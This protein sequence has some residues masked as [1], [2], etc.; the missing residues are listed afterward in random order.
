MKSIVSTTLASYVLAKV[1]HEE[2]RKKFVKS[3]F[4]NYDSSVTNIAYK[5]NFSTRLT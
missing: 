5:K 3:P 2:T 4:E 1:V